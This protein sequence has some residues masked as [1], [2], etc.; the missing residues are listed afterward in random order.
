VIISVINPNTSRA[1]TA[2]IERTA[3]EVAGPGTSII[4]VTC[5]FGPA[6]IES[7]HDHA[8]AVPGVLAA[9][10]PDTSS[11][12]HPVSATVIACFGDPGLDAAREIA[13]GPVLGI[14]EAAMHAASLVARTF[15]I[16]TTLSRT[17]GHTRELVH[18]YGFTRA[19]AGIHACGI[20]VLELDCPESAALIGNKCREALDRDGSDAIVLGCAGMTDLASSLSAELSVPVIDGV[21][22]AVKLAEALVSLG[23]GTSRRSEYAPPRPK[24]VT[25]P[26]TCAEPARACCDQGMPHLLESRPAAGC[27][28]DNS[29]LPSREPTD[30]KPFPAEGATFHGKLGLTGREVEL[31]PVQC[32]PDRPRVDNLDESAAQADPPFLQAGTVENDRTFTSHFDWPAGGNWLRVG[33]L[34]CTFLALVPAVTGERRQAEGA[35]HDQH[36]DGCDDDDGYRRR[37]RSRAAREWVKHRA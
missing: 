7:H 18:R 1:M 29:W 20:P 32:P 14:A 23:L 26:L 9:I 24:E 21:A 10:S 12:T 8:L 2:D 31:A 34:T 5:P 4:A 27:Y 36:E 28:P 3:R 35:A 37:L 13:D 22:A 17:I 25:G 11:A 15:S 16:V 33:L 30:D 6:S 19:C